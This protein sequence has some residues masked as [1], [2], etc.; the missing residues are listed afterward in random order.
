[1]TD[2]V[3]LTP[4]TAEGAAPRALRSALYLHADLL[5]DDAH[6]PLTHSDHSH[7]LKKRAALLLTQ[8]G[9]YGNASFKI[10]AGVN[11]GWR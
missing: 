2:F 7:Q 9:A 3:H 11:A 1:M 6:N 8:L 5:S 4:H 10:V